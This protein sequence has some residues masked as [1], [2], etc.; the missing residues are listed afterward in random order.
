MA[1]LDEFLWRV[2][3][4]FT[5]VNLIDNDIIFYKSRLSLFEDL[6]IDYKKLGKFDF[7]SLDSISRGDS[8]YPLPPSFN[9][10]WFLKERFKLVNNLYQSFWRDPVMI[11]DLKED[12]SGNPE[13]KLSSLNRSHFIS[14]RTQNL[15]C[16]NYQDLKNLYTSSGSFNDSLDFFKNQDSTFVLPLYELSLSTDNLR[17]SRRTLAE[18]L[19]INMTSSGVLQRESLSNLTLEGEENINV[20]P[21]SI[22]SK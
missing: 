7:E 13:I 4:V 21:F 14:N 10:D 16:Y 15:P 1:G 11:L 20:G 17:T 3:H 12:E 8:H 9:G 18:F 6:N 5:G 22:I 19:K 2:S